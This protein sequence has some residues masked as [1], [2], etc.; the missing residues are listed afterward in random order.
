MPFIDRQ[1]SD[2]WRDNHA[3]FAALCFDIDGTL[4]RGGKPLAGTLRLFESLRVD[5]TPFIL[6][7]NDGNHSIEE[8]R[9]ALLKA[10][11]EVSTGEIVSCGHAL[12]PLSKARNLTGRKFFV[13]GDLGNYAEQAGL[14]PVCEIDAIDDCDGVIVGESNYDWEPTFNAV[15]N[16]FIRN[17]EGMLITPN[18][19]TYWPDNHD[20]NL[21]RRRRQGKVHPARARGIWT[22]PWGDRLPWQTLHADLHSGDG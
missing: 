16:Y 3:R 5:K 9:A 2:W 6:L 20:G 17:P 14:V 22:A 10:G 7:T 13:M 12:A 19:D 1:L 15:V 4:V 8:K 11:L 18:P 21:H